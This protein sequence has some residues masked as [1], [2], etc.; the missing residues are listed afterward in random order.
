MSKAWEGERGSRVLGVLGFRGF[1]AKAWVLR[2]I[3]D[4]DI[5]E[6][7][8][9]DRSRKRKMVFERES[10][11]YMYICLHICI[12]ILCICLFCSLAG[13]LEIVGAFTLLK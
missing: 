12:Y 13:F 6:T 9:R 5:F 7:E 3:D 1:P 8:E 10:M 11:I 4:D 2:P